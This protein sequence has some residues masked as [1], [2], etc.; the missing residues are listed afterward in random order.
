[1]KEIRQSYTDKVSEPANGQSGSKTYAVTV[2]KAA[3]LYAGVPAFILILLIPFL[4]FK[5]PQLA[6][7]S[8]LFLIVYGVLIKKYKSFFVEQIDLLLFADKV[9]IKN[10]EITEVNFNR[11]KD[12]NIEKTWSDGIN[13][14][15]TLKNGDKIK[16]RSNKT[17]EGIKNMKQ[18]TIDFDNVIEPLIMS[19]NIQAKRK[20]TFIESPIFMVLFIINTLLVLSGIAMSFYFK[21]PMPPFV[22]ICT[23]LSIPT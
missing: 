7:L 16:L 15:I 21:K 9:I 1:M 6:V 10:A 5:H 4:Y 20:K 11:I 14:T 2:A 12:Y 18:F 3:Y 17:M 22:W 8:I 13:L 19:G 23:G